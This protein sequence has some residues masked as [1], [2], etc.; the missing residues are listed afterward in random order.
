MQD[1]TMRIDIV[2]DVVCPWCIIGYRRLQQALE[3]LDDGT[4][5]SVHWQ[6]FELNPHMLPEGQD[7]REHVQEKYGT[8]AEESKAA[9]K[10]MKA[11]AASLGVTFDYA[12]DMRIRNTFKAHQL[13]HWAGEGDLQTVLKEALFEAYFTRQENVDDT[14]VLLA[15]VERAGLPRD[16]AAA[17]LG[18]GRYRDSV[19]AAEQHWVNQGIHGVPAFIFNHR[20]LVSGAQEPQLFL[21]L[22]QRMRQETAA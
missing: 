13:L 15:A 5:V 21:Q 3:Q 16:E 8:T 22:F 19:R 9:R 2:S 18:D 1:D 6:P 7:L 10:R 12:D 20:Y 17:V 4:R 11:L 14:E